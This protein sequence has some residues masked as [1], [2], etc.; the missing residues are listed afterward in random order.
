MDFIYI[1]FYILHYSVNVNLHNKLKR[2]QSHGR[3]AN[4]EAMS[5]APNVNRLRRELRAVKE[6]KKR[7]KVPSS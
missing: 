7:Q 6:A 5:L 2:A 3:V 4:H 1:Y